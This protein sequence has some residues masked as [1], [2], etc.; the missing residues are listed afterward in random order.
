MDGFPTLIT[1]AFERLTNSGLVQVARSLNATENGAFGFTFSTEVTQPNNENLPQLVELRAVIPSDFPFKAV[2]IFPVSPEL[3]GFP[4][5]DAETGK[6]CLKEESKAPCT[7]E[8]LRVYVEWSLEWLQ[9]AAQGKL[10]KNGDPYELPDFSTKRLKDR[11]LLKKEVWFVE[12]RESFTYWQNRVGQTG[13]VDLVELKSPSVL[14]ARLF[15]GSDGTE[16]KARVSPTFSVEGGKV[17]AS[18]VLLPSL[19]YRRNR[20]PQIFEEICEKCSALGID[21][22]S[23]LRGLCMGHQNKNPYSVLLIGAPI[24]RMVGEAPTEVHWQPIFL[25]TVYGEPSDKVRTYGKEKREKL[26][27]VRDMESHFSGTDLNGAKLKEV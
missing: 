27:R 4:H 2:E 12:N 19:A 6:L 8:R 18:W 7:A 25:K 5:Q 17:S 13:L 15:K 10:L 14:F 26:W 11:P 23:I 9:D 3:F 20:P 22:A 1:E 16:W 24:P 21:L